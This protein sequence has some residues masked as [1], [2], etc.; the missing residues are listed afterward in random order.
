[1]N[2]QVAQQLTRARTSLVLDQPFL[3]MLALRLAMVEDPSIK[4]AAV[5]GRSLFYNPDFIARLSPAKTIT[6][7]AHEVGHCMFDHIGRRGDRNH[8]KYNQAGDYVINATLKDAGF[9]EIDDW[10]FN[11]AFAGMSSDHIYALLPD[12]EE[13]NDP[14][15]DCRD[16][17]A[18]SAE[19]DAIEWKIATIQAAEAAKAMGKLPASMQRFVEELTAA[20]VDWRAILRRFVTETSKDDYSWQRPNRR[21]LNQGF[22]LPTLYSESMGEIIIAID[23]SG[24]IDQTTLNAFG[25][26]VKAI[27]QSS[28]P[29]K[30][31]VIYCDS[32]VNHV[33][34]FGPNDDLV[35]KMHGG[36]GTSF[37]PPFLHVAEKGIQ[38]VCMCYLT[39]M[40]GAFPQGPPD[41]PVLWCA[42]TDI[43]APWGE[44]VRLEI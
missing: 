36:G 14:L 9:E 44:T 7:V 10:L 27:V 11:P 39:D 17:D 35:F 24:S 15:D 40:Y 8:R 22:Y 29:A 23:T 1:M 30:T 42:T 25:S 43:I 32:A 33:D 18:E 19:S 4:S 37:I 12:N 41:F 31:T 3:G 13:G 26:E 20:K 6:L 16:G 38:P 34:E 28:R 21:F 5:D 2:N